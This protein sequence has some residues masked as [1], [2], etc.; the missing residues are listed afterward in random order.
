MPEL[1]EV[2]TVRRTLLPAVGGRISSVWTSGMG[3]HMA[4]KPPRAKLRELVGAEI[5]A[6]RR[7]GKYLL[8]DTDRAASILVHLGMTGR[9][10]IHRAVD[11]RAAHTHV[12]LGL[13]ERE[14]RFVDARRFGQFDV[15]VRGQERAH[16]GLAVLGPD[17]LDEAID[18]AA[19]LA[20]ARDKRTTLKAFVLDQRVIAGV[21]N[22]YASEALWRAQLRPTLRTHKLT[23]A[24]TQRLAAAIREV[25]ERALDHRGTTL[26]DFV[27]ADGTAGENAAYLWVYDRAGQPCLRCQ[28]SIKRSVL[29]GRATYYCPTCQTP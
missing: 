5:T 18:E 8:L 25:I 28:T 15:V 24:S 22:I 1:P 14:L 16:P 10:R 4:R 26:N 23:A 7:H 17:A 3:L 13:E 20:A 29:Q 21:G 9:L 19:L 11:P 12:V 27:D 2:E 6:V